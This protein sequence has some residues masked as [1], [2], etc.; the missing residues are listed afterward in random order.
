MCG[1]AGFV[2]N[3]NC[4]DDELK[5]RSRCMADAISHRG[6]DSEGYWT[7]CTMGVALAHRRLSI[8]DLSER[9][10]QPMI[11]QC[12][13]LVMVYNGEIYNTLDIL[14]ELGDYSPRGTSDT[15]LILEACARWGIESAVT[16]LVGMFAL[17]IWNRKEQTLVM[18]RDRVGIKPLYW[19]IIE[20]TLIF[21]SE[22]KALTQHPK[23]PTSLNRNAIA[24][25]LRKAY[26]NGPDS[27]YE[28]VNKLLPGHILTFPKNGTPSTKKYWS[29]KS[30]ALRAQDNLFTGSIDEAIGRLESLLVDAVSKRMIADVPLGAFLS[31]GIDSS[32]VTAIMQRHSTKPIRTFSIGFGEKKYN[33]AIYAAAV[34]KY[35]GTQHTELYVDAKQALEVIPNLHSMFDEPFSDTSQIPTYIVSKMTRQHVTV[36][37]SG[38]G[39]D[40]LFAGYTRYFATHKYRNILNQPKGLRI[41]EARLLESLTP[42]MASLIA[43]FLPKQLG[44]LLDSRNIR[45]IPPFLRSGRIS[46]LYKRTRSRVENPENLLVSGVELSDPVWE[47]AD[48]MRFGDDFALMQYIDMLDYLP[49]DILTKLDRTS[50]AVSLEARVPLLDH[51]LIEFA[52]TLPLNMKYRNGEGK[53]LLKQV[54]AKYLPKELIERPKK[55]FSVPIGSWLKDPL[56]DWAEDL[57]SEQSLLETEVFKPEIIRKRWQE[58]TSGEVNWDHH[59]W[60]V[61]IMQDWLRHNT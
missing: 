38:D 30:I 37:L 14:E 2:T 55:G 57:L 39:G 43:K 4:S 22:L 10:A 17:V 21:G 8:L 60:D 19:T 48:A 36:A 52:S 50:M 16:R 29:L 49:G 26:I 33:E 15:E 35:L 54:L 28:G 56:K 44:S 13:N 32:T 9:G 24:S 5:F 6:P 42:E 58:H 18:V 27:I 20:G 53:W 61:L 23:C 41:L 51:R 1:I 45:R 11:S 25:F 47:E 31:G 40:E 12:G 46:S 34:S 59:L 7:D 3:D